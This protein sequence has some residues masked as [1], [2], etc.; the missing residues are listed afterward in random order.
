MK[1]EAKNRFSDPLLQLTSWPGPARGM[2]RRGAARR[3]HGKAESAQSEGKG[4][5]AKQTPCH[6]EEERETTQRINAREERKGN[7][8]WARKKG[9]GNSG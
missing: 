8:E 7:T 5:K 4:N 3:G 1:K 6:E 9:N 2:A